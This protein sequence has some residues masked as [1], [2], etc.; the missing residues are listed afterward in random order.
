MSVFVATSVKD[1][2]AASLQSGVL[3]SLGYGDVTLNSVTRFTSADGRYILFASAI[4]GVIS[5]KTTTAIDVFR[6]DLWTGDIVRASTGANGAE[7]PANSVALSISG[8]GRYVA[9]TNSANDIV[10]N[11]F[12]GGTDVY[13]KDLITGQ[14]IRITETASG[15]QANS[16]TQGYNGVQMTPDGRYFSFYTDAS[17]L[18]PGDTDGS[19]DL[20]WKDT[21]TGKILRIAAPGIASEALHG[22]SMSDDGRY[23]LFDSPASSV[24]A[25]DTNGVSDIFRFDTQTG[26]TLRVSTTSSGAQ[27]NGASNSSQISPDGRYV[28]FLSYASNLVA[29]D[30]NGA[31]DWLVKDMVTGAVVLAKDAPAGAPTVFHYETLVSGKDSIWRD[32]QTDQSIVFYT[33][34]VVGSSKLGPIYD[35][36]YQVALGTSDGKFITFWSLTYTGSGALAIS[37]APPDPVDEWGAPVGGFQNNDSNYQAYL[38]LMGSPLQVSQAGGAPGSV[39]IQDPV[40]PAKTTTWPWA[41]GSFA[42]D[43]SPPDA[44]LSAAVANI[45]RT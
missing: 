37:L 6:Q 15:V 32:M 28:K 2:M 7:L 43:L 21:V 41:G 31:P 30:T 19:L 45:L 3:T 10:A 5:A 34:Q 39:S 35:W 27:A 33:S 11:D 16:H 42:I 20:F 26:T 36:P 23:I 40:N 22:G 1:F 12:G 44:G 18:A 9:F 17:N 24:V 14:I 8:D 29:G 25:G 4:P 13:R 38:D